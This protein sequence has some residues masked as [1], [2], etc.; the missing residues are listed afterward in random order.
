[1]E[2]VRHDQI[3]AIVNEYQLILSKRKAIDQAIGEWNESILQHE[4]RIDQTRNK[5]SNLPHYL[6][7]YE[8]RFRLKIEWAKYQQEMNKQFIKDILNYERL[9]QILTKQA[10]KD[11][12]DSIDKL[13][14][15]KQFE[16]SESSAHDI[17]Q[18]FFGGAEGIIKETV[19]KMYRKLTHNYKEFKTMDN[20]RV[21]KKVIFKTFG[22]Y[23]TIDQLDDI[24]TV[25]NMVTGN[26]KKSHEVWNKIVSKDK[27]KGEYFDAKLFQNGNVH[28]I[29]T[30][31]E[32]LEKFNIRVG[33][34][35]NWL[36]G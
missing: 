20:W 7:K 1:M 18:S 3:A 13:S 34:L 5:V 36:K 15:N 22:I 35:F 14:R 26:N 27:V 2:I 30:D 17:I 19:E 29:F 6:L 33:K 12:Y 31:L 28:I 10:K 9:E 21:G 11:L 16:I 4:Y 23:D 8:A 24:E 32:T 25:L